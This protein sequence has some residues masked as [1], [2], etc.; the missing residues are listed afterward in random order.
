MVSEF[1]FVKI[2]IVVA[3]SY[4]CL[5]YLKYT[6]ISK[7]EQCPAQS[8]CYILANIIIIISQNMAI[9]PKQKYLS[10]TETGC[11]EMEIDNFEPWVLI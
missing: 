11:F 4:G 5:K 9:F 1:S 6:N 3:I 2:E 7:T 10:N 8:E